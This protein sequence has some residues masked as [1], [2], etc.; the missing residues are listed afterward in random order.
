MAALNNGVI[1][2][3]EASVAAPADAVGEV[4]VEEGRKWLRMMDRDWKKDAKDTLREMV[5]MIFSKWDCFG[6]LVECGLGVYDP[7][8][9]NNGALLGFHDKYAVGI[10]FRF[11]Y[12][13]Q[14]RRPSRFLESGVGLRGSSV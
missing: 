10:D 7:V 4:A 6:A 9:G 1:K 11:T 13:F 3:Q 14:A 5:W 2:V 8:P 12:P